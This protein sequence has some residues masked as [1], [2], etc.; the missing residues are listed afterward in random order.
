MLNE[1]V[2]TRYEARRLT[3]LI[4]IPLN[5]FINSEYQKIEEAKRVAEYG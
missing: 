5:S 3:D 2:P 1:F 4:P